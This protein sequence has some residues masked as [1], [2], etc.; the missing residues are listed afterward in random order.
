MH[1]TFYFENL[2]ESSKLGD[3]EVEGNII[4]KW[5]CETYSKGN[6]ELRNEITQEYLKPD[7]KFS[8][9]GEARGR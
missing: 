6:N 8:A 1:E 5:V 9:D 2:R 4:L 3:L 7:N